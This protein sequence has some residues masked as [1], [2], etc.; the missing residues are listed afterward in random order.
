MQKKLINILFLPVTF[1]FFILICSGCSNQPN[2][3][4][5]AG[6]DW[7]VNLADNFS[8]HFSKLTEINKGNIGRLQ[9][10]WEY[11]TGDDVRENRSQIQCNPIIINGILYGT[12]PKLK[13]F[14]LNAATGKQIWEFDPDTSRKSAENVNRGVSF[15]REGS[16]KRILFTS[17]PF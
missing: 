2:K 11:H 17:G 10:A 1:V 3:D 16:D 6:K 12:S 5:G 14:A 4:I 13:V 9:L 15:W 8:S 7:T